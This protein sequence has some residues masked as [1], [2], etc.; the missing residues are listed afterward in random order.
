MSGCC[1]AKIAMVVA[2]EN[3][4][5]RLGWLVGDLGNFVKVQVCF[6][7]KLTDGGIWPFAARTCRSFDDARLS[8]ALRSLAA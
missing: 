1:A 4:L 7:S 8:G 2:F 5:R 6:S 3:V